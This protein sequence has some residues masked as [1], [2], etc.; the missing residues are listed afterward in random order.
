MNRQEA[1][2]YIRKQEPIFL[3]KAPKKINGAYSYICPNCGNGS[4][5][6]GTGITFVPGTENA[7]K[8]HCF[9]CGLQGDVIELF[10]AAG[11]GRPSSAEEWALMFE[12][13]YETYN[14]ATE[15]NKD[16]STKG[17]EKPKEPHKANEGN[18]ISKTSQWGF[19]KDCVAN[20]GHTEYFHDR[21][22]SD[23]VI[24]K[25]WLGYDI[26]RAFAIIPT[27]QYSYVGR[28]TKPECKKEERYRKQG[29]ATIFNAKAIG[30]KGR[31]MPL[32]IAEGELDALSIIEAGADAIGLGGTSN[33][34]KLLKELASNRPEKGFILALDNDQPGKETAAKLKEE[35]EALDIPAYRFNPYGACKDAN[36]ALLA[37][38]ENFTQ[39]IQQ[40]L[41]EALGAIERELNR[42][43]NE[44]EKKNSVASHLQAF[45]NGIAESVNTAYIPTGFERLDKV[46]DGGLYEGLY[47]IGAISSLGKTTMA[48]QIADQVAAGG[49]DVIIFSLE[50]ARMELMAKSISRLTAQI[51]ENENGLGL[52]NAKT[53]RGITVGKWYSQYTDTEK[54]VIEKAVCQ[55][56][57][58][59]GRIYIHE[60]MGDIDPQK[61]RREVA[62]HIDLIGN[63]PVVL[64]DYVQIIAPSD[65]RASDKQNTDKAVLE[66]K[67]ISRDFKIPVIGISSFNRAS[68]K[69]AVSM[70][71]FKES[72]GLEYGSDVLIGLQ[73]QGVGSENFDVN[74][75]KQQHPRNVELVILKNRNGQTGAKLEYYYNAMYNYFAE[76]PEPKANTFS[77]RGK[78][79]GH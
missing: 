38:R 30:K 17:H 57:E 50:M 2:D 49:N 23:A 20:V 76:K 61:I 39:K 11:W 45:I 5:S 19:I 46:L 36:E 35:L 72:G 16:I 48:L 29:P 21:G 1:K 9:K 26:K 52:E 41:S 32:Y 68:Y 10:I 67:R 40:G 78:R 14:I 47:I 37:D 42:L 66:L 8:Y 65:V 71:A 22:L 27:S 44:Y 79:N 3:D 55:Y 62:R 64:V 54:E 77:V 63:K 24:K 28:N 58:F 12:S 43:R 60:G 74:A 70:E 25:Y 6:D 13:L 7:R 59:A 33:I 53:T 75:A 69:D 56:G 51:V 34:G 15:E 31:K 4:G 73:L 18:D